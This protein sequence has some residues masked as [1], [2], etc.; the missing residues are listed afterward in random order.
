MATVEM[1]SQPDNLTPEQE[2]LAP[3]PLPPFTKT[4]LTYCMA[5]GRCKSMKHYL[6]ILSLIFFSFSS[7]PSM[8]N[9]AMI[10]LFNQQRSIM[11]ILQICFSSFC[12][13]SYFSFLSFSYLPLNGLDLPEVTKGIVSSDEGCRLCSPLDLFC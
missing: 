7:S 13:S 11:D 10:I 6:V 9:Q 8:L 12:F 5:R 2:P 4:S 1:G 3:L